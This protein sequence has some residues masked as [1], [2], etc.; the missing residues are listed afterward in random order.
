MLEHNIEDKR[1]KKNLYKTRDQ[2]K[3]IRIYDKL[4]IRIPGLYTRTVFVNVVIMVYNIPDVS[5]FT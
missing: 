3:R 5:Q 1:E 4:R 2:K